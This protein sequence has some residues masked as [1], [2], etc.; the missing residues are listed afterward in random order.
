MTV[1]TPHAVKDDRHWLNPPDWWKKFRP[2]RWLA[3][4]VIIGGL[5][6]G[7]WGA[8]EI[9][10]A[11]RD[12]PETARFTAVAPDP[13]RFGGVFASYASVEWTRQRNH[14]PHSDRY[15]PRHLDTLRAPAFT[16][17]G[18]AGALTLEF[19]NNRLFEMYFEPTDPGAYSAALF[20]SDARLKK[21]R[22]GKVEI[23]DGSLRLA[24]NVDLADSKVGTSLRT[25]PFAIWQDLRLVKQSQLWDAEYGSIP[26]PRG[27]G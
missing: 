8:R 6:S 9:T 12:H 15:P 27:S 16:H 10:L 3:I 1:R 23:V 7:L 2:L 24:T 4:A 13:L 19:F 17:L 18:V 5:G 11:P 26:V 14:R 21:N 25:K 22:L 20:R